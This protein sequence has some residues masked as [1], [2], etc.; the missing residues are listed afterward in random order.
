MNNVE[1]IK[2]LQATNGRIEKEEILIKAWKS[3][4][5]E[6]FYG[7][8]LCYDPFTTFGV[9]DK[10]VSVKTENVKAKSK[11]N[12]EEFQEFV[13]LAGKLQRRELTGHAAQQEIHNFSLLVDTELFNLFYRPILLKDMRIGLTDGTANKAL[14]KIGKE[15]NEYIIASF[16][17]QLAFDGVEEV[18]EGKQILQEKLDGVRILAVCDKEANSVTLYTRN[19]KENNNLPH[20]KKV[21]EDMLPTLTESMVF[22]GEVTAENFQAMMTQINR[23]TNVK[24][25]SSRLALFDVLTLAEFKSEISKKTQLQRIEMLEKFSA[26]SEDPAVFV[27]DKIIVDMS[28][29]KGK[30]EFADFNAKAIAAGKEGIMVKKPDAPYECKRSKSW[31]KIK[32]FIS[33]TLEIVGFELGSGKNSNRLGN[34]L[35]EGE[36]DGKQVKVSVGS[37]ITE[38][39]RDEFWNNRNSLMGMLIEVKADALTL[40]ENSDNIY[41]MRFPRFVGFRGMVPGEK[42]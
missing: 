19:G 21:F 22:D 7:L 27:L 4:N 26:F 5:R 28:T 3:G 14:K 35:C 31:L 30:K 25:E 16:S 29:T 17:C 34:F 12:W 33:E 32:P 20:I 18:F 9:A 23:K 37:G 36:V 11:P 2:A 13:A 39:Q 42:I 38:E 8:K 10:T 24:S 40:S 6:F 41:S 15:A 1:I